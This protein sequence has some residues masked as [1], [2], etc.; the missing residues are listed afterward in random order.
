MLKLA[1]A[2]AHLEALKAEVS[3]YWE[4]EPC[5]LRPDLDCKGGTYSLRIE[6]RESTPVGW[7]VI[8]GDFV[9]NLRS[10]LDHMACQLARI[11]N[12][13][14]NIDRTQF[15]IFVKEPTHGKALATWERYTAGM[16]HRVIEEI[17]KMQPY[18][19][20]DGAKANALAILNALSN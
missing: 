13:A 9:H 17:R 2:Q 4:R 16:G 6:I 12:P 8:V 19:A 5:G 10:A 11:E 1:R 3:A 14:A 7:S 15:P 18:N 20:G